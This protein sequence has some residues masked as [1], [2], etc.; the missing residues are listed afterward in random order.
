MVDALGEARVRLTQA[1][2]ARSMFRLQL[3]GWSVAQIAAANLALVTAVV[4]G[5]DGTVAV[6]CW[7]LLWLASAGL[8]LR[9]AY[10]MGRAVNDARWYRS[11]V[12]GGSD[13]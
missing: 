12:N 10:W 1:D 2:A 11:L 13:E 5:R 6:I 9:A 8:A 3:V 4:A 7:G